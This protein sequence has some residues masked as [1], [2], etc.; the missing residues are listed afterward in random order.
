MAQLVFSRREKKYLMPEEVYR[1]FMD[2]LLR[3]MEIDRYGLHTICNIYLDTSD[4]LLVRRSIEKPIYKEKLRLR[5]YGVPGPDQ[6]VFLEIKKKYQGIVT[7]RRA[8]LAL[9]EANDYLDRGIRPSKDSQILREIDFFLERYPLKK[10]LFLAYDRI[11]LFGRDDPEF[12]VTFDTGIRSR[13]VMTGLENG[14]GGAFLLPEGWHLMESKITGA[15]PLWFTRLLSR[16]SIYP[17]SFSKYGSIYKKEHGV[18]NFEGMMKHR[19]ECWM[20]EAAGGHD[21]EGSIWREI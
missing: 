16:Y 5:S 1:P 14:D 7:K 4:D 3:S 21:D 18:W 11:A 19:Q 15:V 20:P 17:T 2:D 10:R 6:T 9:D 12:R 8:E 13:R